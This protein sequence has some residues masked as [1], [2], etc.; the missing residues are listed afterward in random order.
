M[1]AGCLLTFILCLGYYI[2]PAL[3]GGPSDQMLSYY[4]AYYLN[5]NVNWSMAAAVSLVLLL[6]TLAIYVLY[7]RVVPVLRQTES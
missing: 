5:Q 6:I 4:V 7:V 1:A 2:T 3:L